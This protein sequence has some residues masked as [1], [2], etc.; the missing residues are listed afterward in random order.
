M[1][2]CDRHLVQMKEQYLLS[3]GP[4]T[5]SVELLSRLGITST[6]CWRE[7]KLHLVQAQIT[8]SLLLYWL[9]P[10]SCY[11]INCCTYDVL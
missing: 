9:E 5:L 7:D 8:K 6:L 2:P 1:H 10:K 4:Y 11:P 3:T